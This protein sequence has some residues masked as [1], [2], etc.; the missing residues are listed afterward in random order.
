MILPGDQTLAI[1]RIV[2]A[3][4]SRVFAAWTD[5][6]HLKEWFAPEGYRVQRCEADPR[7]GG[8]LQLTM[9]SACGAEY[10]VHGV[11]RQ[12][13]APERVVIAW[14]ESVVDVTLAERAGCTRLTLKAS[15]TANRSARG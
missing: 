11:F 10:R 12:V 2:N 13:V 1:T 5:P 7:P 4:R 6:E 15:G 8:R 14:G 9:R 3:P